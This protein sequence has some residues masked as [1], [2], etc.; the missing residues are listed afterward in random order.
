MPYATLDFSLGLIGVAT[1]AGG[2]FVIRELKNV[3][4]PRSQYTAFWG[5]AL[6]SLLRR[7]LAGWWVPFAKK[8]R[9]NYERGPLK[10]EYKIYKSSIDD[11]ATATLTTLGCL[12]VWVWYSNFGVSSS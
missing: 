3:T 11:V 4:S 5:W 2:V 8:Y 9:E 12:L 7:R 1:A 6:Y 10:E